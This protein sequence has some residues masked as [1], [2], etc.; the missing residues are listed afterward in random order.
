M[1]LHRTRAEVQYKVTSQ[2]PDY[3]TEVVTWT[4]LKFVWCEIRDVLPSR[5][6]DVMI[7]DS[8]TVASRRTRIRMR[9]RTDIDTS[10]RLI[11]KRG[12]VERIYQLI[13]GPAEIGNRQ[14]IEFIA[15]W[16]TAHAT[17]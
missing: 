15:E 1:R 10:M 12:D 6:E 8:L 3:G 14:F 5:H 4:F 7:N 16:T 11:T 13:S 9:Y 2:D 17:Q